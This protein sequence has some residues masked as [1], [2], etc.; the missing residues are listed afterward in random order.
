MKD[1][2][3]TSKDCEWRENDGLG[4]EGVSSKKRVDG[5]EATV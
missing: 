5:R 4:C 2:R 1:Q 3:L